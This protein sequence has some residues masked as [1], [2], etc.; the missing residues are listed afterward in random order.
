MGINGFRISNVATEQIN[1]SCQ[2]FLTCKYMFLGYLAST[3]N[4]FTTLR[5]T[6]YM[7]TSTLVLVPGIIGDHIC[8]SRIEQSNTENRKYTWYEYEFPHIY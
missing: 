2:I 7:I 1:N 4:C 5:S 8:G 3:V 6:Y